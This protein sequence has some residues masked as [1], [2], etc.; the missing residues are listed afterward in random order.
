MN[1][2][3]SLKANFMKTKR[4]P[5]RYIILLVP[6]LFSLLFVSYISVYKR[7]YTFQLNVYNFY[8]SIIS[9][10]LPLISSI[11]IGLNIMGEETSGEFRGLLMTPI[12][13]STIYLSKLFMIILV[14]IIDMFVSLLIL[15]IGMK[16]LYPL[17]TIQYG[18][19]LTGTILTILGCLFLYGL[20][21]IIS[22]KFGIGPTIAVGV[23]GSIMGAL[24]QTGLGDTIWPFVPF[25][26]SGRIGIVPIYKLSNFIKYQHLENKKNIQEILNTTFKQYMYLGVPIAIIS[27]IIICAIGVLWFNK[28]EGRKIH[29]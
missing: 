21:L 16:F 18:V 5:F 4:T 10:T 7:D 26:W 8:F 2:L 29:D 12:S 19:F 1:F 11:L 25:A 6:I 13:R 23:G 15:L 28:W 9:I 22:L 3:R 17:G 27:F 20:Y 14:T 24:L